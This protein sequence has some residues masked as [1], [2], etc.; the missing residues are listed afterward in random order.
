MVPGISRLHVHEIRS[1][2]LT[3]VCEWSGLLQEILDYPLLLSDGRVRQNC[4]YK[5]EFL[6]V[7]QDCF[8]ITGV[9]SYCSISDSVDD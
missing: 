6:M 4:H 5:I 9:N 7:Y 1:L 8:G 2:K 3:N